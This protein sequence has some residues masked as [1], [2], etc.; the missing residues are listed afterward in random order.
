M[1]ELALTAAELCIWVVSHMQEPELLGGG[2]GL[3]IL[4][5]GEPKALHERRP[6][7]GHDVECREGE[8]QLVPLK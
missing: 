1:G 5:D 3:A 7:C 2:A 4:R 8:A 6:S